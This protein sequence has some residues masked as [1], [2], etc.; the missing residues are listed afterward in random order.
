V[1]K[2]TCESWAKTSQDLGPFQFLFGD[3]MF[4]RADSDSLSLCKLEVVFNNNSRTKIDLLTNYKIFQQ[5]KI[6]AM[7]LTFS[8]HYL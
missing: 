8:I 3:I 7:K 5:D 6:S 2:G 1:L 4:R